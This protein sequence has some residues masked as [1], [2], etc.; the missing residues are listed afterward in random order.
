MQLTH[1][2]LKAWHPLHD[3]PFHGN[4]PRDDTPHDAL[5]RHGTAPLPRK[6]LQI[7]Q[8]L[9]LARSIDRQCR[10]VQRAAGLIGFEHAHGLPIAVDWRVVAG[11]PLVGWP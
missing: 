1:R 6:E 4:H 7:A 8:A 2:S 3:T 10:A 9:Q 11:R 5:V